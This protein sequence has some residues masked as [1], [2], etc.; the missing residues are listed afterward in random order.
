MDFSTSLM[1]LEA[2]ML[3]KIVA[4]P[5]VVLVDGK[6]EVLKKHLIFYVHVVTL[7]LPR[8]G[9]SRFTANETERLNFE[10]AL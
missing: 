4:N 10:A 3:K 8:F 1:H 6:M 5:Q 7:L 9:A 2:V